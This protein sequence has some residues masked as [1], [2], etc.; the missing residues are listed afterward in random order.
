MI[1][2]I[3]NKKGEGW[4]CFD[5][6]IIHS[7]FSLLSNEPGKGNFI[8]LLDGVRDETEKPI[9]ILQLEQWDRSYITVATN[10]VSYILNDQGKTVDRI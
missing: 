1:V 10:R 3:S 5:C 9:K 4:S 8:Y 6:K 7:R 2:K